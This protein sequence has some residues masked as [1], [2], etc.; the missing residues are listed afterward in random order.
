M[1]DYKIIKK[2]YGEKFARMCRE[3]FPT[4]L[5]KEGLLSSL[6]MSKFAYPNHYLYDDIVGDIE[7]NEFKNYIYSFIDV[8]RKELFTNKSVRQ[9]F[10]EAGYDFY[11]CNCEEDIHFFKKYYK[12]DEKLCTFNGNRLAKCFVFWAVR[13]NVD[14]IKREDFKNPKRQDEYGTSVISIQFDRGMVNTLSIKNR[15]NHKVN[16]PNATFSNDLENIIPGLTNAF[17]REYGF[18]MNKYSS[19]NFR[20]SNYVVANDKK[21]YKYNYVISNV[22]YCPGNIMIKNGEVMKLDT[23]RYLLMDYFVLDISNKTLEFRNDFLYDSF[24]DRFDNIVRIRIE[25]IREDNNKLVIITLKNKDKINIILNELGQI[26]GIED[27][28]LTSIKDSFLYYNRSMM[29][30]NF[31]NLISIGNNFLFNNNSL[32]RGVFSKLDS[33]GD[34]CLYNNKLLQESNYNE[35]SCL[36]NY[37]LIEKLRSL[38]LDKDFNVKK[39]IRLKVY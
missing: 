13:K 38:S 1:D 29:I 14:S 10:D 35:L 4:I 26:I 12:D 8:E 32:V 19:S 5:E 25:R 20:L 24:I 2:N 28:N 30:A 34:F 27:K 17:E 15:Y 7:V 18:L 3:L 33:I 39:K 22:Y 16:N 23:S 6:I 11:E 36:A 37:H 31:P 9:L 21:Y